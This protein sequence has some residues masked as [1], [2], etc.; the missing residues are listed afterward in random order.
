MPTWIDLELLS[1]VIGESKRTHAS[2]NRRPLQLHRKG[3]TA[4]QKYLLQH[5]DE[6]R[7][8]LAKQ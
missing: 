1:T 7:A 2:K 3:I 6:L 5:K 8:A 4:E